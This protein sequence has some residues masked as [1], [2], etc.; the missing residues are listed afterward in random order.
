MKNSLSDMAQNASE[1]VH[2][3]GKRVRGE[4]IGVVA[5]SETQSLCSSKERMYH[6]APEI[7]KMD[8][9]E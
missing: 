1:S 4:G 8:L 6:L 7:I 3:R 5:G 9:D 2:L